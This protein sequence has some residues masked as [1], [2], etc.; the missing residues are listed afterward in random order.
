MQGLLC[1]MAE[2]LK[3]TGRFLL[4]WAIP[5][6]SM[7]SIRWVTFLKGF[8]TSLSE[9]FQNFIQPWAMRSPIYA[10]TIIPAGYDHGNCIEPYLLKWSGTQ[11]ICWMPAS[12]WAFPSAL[13]DV[14]D[15]NY[16]YITVWDGNRRILRQL[17]RLAVQTL[18]AGT[19]A[20]SISNPQANCICH[21]LFIY[22]WFIPFQLN[23]VYLHCE[24]G[25]KRTSW[26]NRWEATANN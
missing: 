12:L 23:F 7:L 3:K 22:F 25:K 11:E 1:V 26:L 20:L 4:V 16:F 8:R 18:Q 15:E 9:E 2:F 14:A 19:N 13:S 24:E 10:N 21:F 6:M 5:G 17:G